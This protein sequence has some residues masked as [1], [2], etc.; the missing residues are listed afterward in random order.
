MINRNKL[1]KPF[2][3]WVGGKRQL[4]DK[5][6]G[7]LPVKYTNY[8][9]PFVGGAALLFSL[10]PQRAVI[11][12]RNTDLIRVYRVVRDQ[13][14]ELIENLQR[15]KNEADYFYNIRALDRKPQFDNLSDVE[16]AGRVVYLNKTCFNSLYRVNNAGEFNAPFGGYKNP[17]IVNTT[18]IRVVSNY[19]NKAKIEILNHDFEVVLKN[20]RGSST[21]VY[22]DPPYDPVSK[23][24]N[25]TGYNQ[26]GFGKDEQVRLRDLCDRLNRRGVKFL[27]S[28]SATDFIKDLYQNYT[29][30]TIKAVRAINSDGAKRGGVNELLIY[31]Y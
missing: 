26:G 23:S 6:K 5:I 12:D 21:F 13:P 30:E 2:L 24:A 15:H 9:E 31:N 18:T 3:K 29:I 8:Y 7:R 25:F 28:N 14:E 10:Q 16:K 4:L 27:L 1:V 22:L 19:L 17:N 20:I 11:N